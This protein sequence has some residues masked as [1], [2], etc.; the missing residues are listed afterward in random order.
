MLSRQLVTA[1]E[2]YQQSTYRPPVAGSGDT[3]IFAHSLTSKAGSGYEKLR[4][5]LEYQEEHAIR[6][7][8]ME[9]ILRRKLRFGN[10]TDLGVPLLQEYVSGGYL[11]NNTIPE[12]AAESVEIIV[13][14]Y[15][16]LLKHLETTA[17]FNVKEVKRWLVSFAATEIHNLF[18]PK[19]AAEVIVEAF[20]ATAHERLRCVSPVP[21]PEKD[22]QT[23]IACRRTLLAS[24]DAETAYSLW[25]KYLPDLYT[26]YAEADLVRLAPDAARVLPVILQQLRKTLS[27]RVAAKLKNYS[28][29]FALLW[30]L[31]E[32]QGRAAT[33]T[34]ANPTNLEAFV[35]QTM[36]ARYAVENK[37]IKKRGTRSV[38]YIF[39]TKIILAAGLEFPYDYFMLNGVV[40]YRA[41][42]VNVVFHPFLLFMM[43]RGIR[44]LGSRNTDAMVGGV[45]KAAYDP[46]NLPILV[47]NNKPSH[48]VWYLL[49]TVLYIGLFTLIFSTIIRGLTA[50]NFNPASTTIFLFFLALVSYFGL[51]IRHMAKRWK[52]E[53]PGEG[54]MSALWGLLTLPIVQAGR[55]LSTTFSSINVFVFILDFIIET[56]FKMLL[57]GLDAFLAF[58]RDK[59][60]EVR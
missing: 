57:R 33:A 28:I 32:Q 44:K 24:T 54:I 12:S 30:N 50:F 18:F 7:G 41:L 23:Y 55:W 35:R 34:M 39:L 15:L 16:F 4:N 22:S 21:D 58:L 40:D 38:A 29:Y 2:K 11:P 14:K 47:V 20:H 43:T 51:R 48:G 9:R 59:R 3:A 17:G 56:P 1:L 6:R 31:L 19:F 60:E 8:A 25:L 27:W 45:L 46:G 49:F 42:G 10:A 53:E 52:V 13:K 5:L 36:E 26:A 37:Q